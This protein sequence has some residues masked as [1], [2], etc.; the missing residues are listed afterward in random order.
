MDFSVFSDMFLAASGNAGLW[1]VLKGTGLVVRLV[2]LL[3]IFA[4][5]ASW[6]ISIF[7]WRQ[8]NQMTKKDSEFLDFFWK[9]R[10][11]DKIFESADTFFPSPVAEVF[12]SGYIELARIRQSWEDLEKEGKKV[13]TEDDLD[14]IER[15][16]RKAHTT[17]MNIA[18]SLVSMLAT[19]G[20]TS[21]FV[22]LFGTVWGIMNSF[23]EIGVTQNA[24]LATVAPGISEALIATAT[25]LAAAIPAVIAYNY[26]IER[27]KIIDTEIE[28]FSRD[29]LNIIKRNFFR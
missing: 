14:S 12:K 5:V 28:N 7:K 3:L 11:L 18:D 15:A 23:H 17:Q 21:P 1:A 4:S 25:G 29:F 8:I 27:T 13:G 6:A 2:L 26:F 22:G 9:T 24:S 16:L 19:I 10:R 20:S